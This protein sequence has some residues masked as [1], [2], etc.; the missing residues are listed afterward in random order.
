M[1]FYKNKLA[2]I[3]NYQIN[4]SNFNTVI[5]R[6]VATEGQT[7]FTLNNTYEVGKNRLKVIVGGIQQFTSTNYT[8][9]SPTSI[10][11]L[12]GLSVGTKVDIEI[13]QIN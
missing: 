11:F 13:T 5:E 10:T 4:S 2:Q 8:E 3:N 9:T 7:V 6:F 1:S 12:E